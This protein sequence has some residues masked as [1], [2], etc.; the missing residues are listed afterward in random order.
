MKWPRDKWLPHHQQP[1]E[2][3]LKGPFAGNRHEVRSQKVR[4]ARDVPGYR[5]VRVP[6]GTLIAQW[7]H[8]RGYQ[9][10]GTCPKRIFHR[11]GLKEKRLSDYT[12]LDFIRL[13]AMIP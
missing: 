12:T 5:R 13:G 8:E 7:R 1:P 11:L 4:L 9:M 10:I 6:F 3:W 2:R